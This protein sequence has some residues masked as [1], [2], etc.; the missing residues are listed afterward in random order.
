[1]TFRIGSISTEGHPRVGVFLIPC[2]GKRG[3]IEDVLLALGEQAFPVLKEKA[4]SYVAGITE[5]DI[6]AKDAKALNKPAGRKKAV[7]G[8]MTAILKPEFATARSVRE[9][10]WLAPEIIGKTAEVQ[11]CIRFLTD[12]LGFAPTSAG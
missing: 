8:S 3:T 6:E 2:E 11:P 10:R 1:M 9:D 4:D 12:L 5:Q 7:V